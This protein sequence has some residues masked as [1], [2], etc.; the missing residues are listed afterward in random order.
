MSDYTATVDLCAI[1][2][3]PHNYVFLRNEKKEVGY[4]RWANMDTFYCSK[5]LKQKTTETEVDSTPTYR[6]SW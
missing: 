1:D 5:C 6:P 4:R 2:G 3:D